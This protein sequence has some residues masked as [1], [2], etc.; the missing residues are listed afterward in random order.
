MNQITVGHV[1]HHPIKARFLGPPPGLEISMDH[2]FNLRQ[3]QLPWGFPV[4]SRNG[5]WGHWQ[6]PGDIGMGPSARMSNLDNDLRP[7][8]MDGLGQTP[9]SRYE[10]VVIDPQHMFE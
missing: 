6:T 4:Q 8:L 7:L 3:A 1:D 10:P 2:L 5:R 9:E